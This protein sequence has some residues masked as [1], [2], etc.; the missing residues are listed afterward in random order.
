[1]PDVSCNHVN[2]N[3]LE[4]LFW[5]LS[6]P[7]GGA[8]LTLTAR[9][10]SPSRRGLSHPLG[11]ACLTLTA[12]PVSPSRRGLS[13]PHGGACLTLTAG[14]HIRGWRAA[15]GGGGG[16]GLVALHLELR[17]RRRWSPPPRIPQTCTHVRTRAR[18]H[19]LTHA[20]TH[21][22]ARACTHKACP[23]LSAAKAQ[24]SAAP[25]RRSDRRVNGVYLRLPNRRKA[26]SEPPHDPPQQCSAG[27][28]A[29]AVAATAVTAAAAA[30]AAVAAAA[31]GRGRQ[32]QWPQQEW[33][34]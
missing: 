18:A 12:G 1:M 4:S 15:G 25:D 34:Y 26:F 3:S 32:E 28:Q 23:L 7:H 14:P 22:R 24:R 19:A 16:A 31:A 8:C 11:G 13:H 29:T 6:H 27:R 33:P 21:A 10:V 20:P 9:P 5:G 30:A 2:S 17:P